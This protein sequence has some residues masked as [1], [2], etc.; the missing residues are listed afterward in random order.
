MKEEII[1]YAL[2]LGFAKV[3]FARAE[4]LHPEFEAYTEWL[5]NGFHAT[6][7]YM[8]E[9]GEK[10]LDVRN[11]LSEATTVIVL[12]FNY[13]SG[14]K[15]N[16]GLSGEKGKISRYA[17]G[18]DYHDIIKPK[19]K[20]I[21]EFIA[22]LGDDV[23]TWVYVDTGPVLEK[24]WASRAGIGWQGKHSIIITREFGSWIFLGIVLTSL[25]IEPDAPVKNFCGKCTKCI[26]A[27]PTSAILKPAVVDS[28]KCI[29]YWTI[30]AKPHML[31][32]VQIAGNMK[33]WLYGCDICQEVCPWNRDLDIIQL[34]ESFAPRN[35]ESELELDRIFNMTS[36]EFTARFRKSPAK[37]TKLDGLKR[38]AET[39]KGNIPNQDKNT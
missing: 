34:N 14:H 29:A 3:G 2:S 26:D 19:L 25:E 28:N 15:H 17:W 37:R 7:G 36:D 21:A 18:D 32:P 6:M 22:S 1:K 23:K 9:N 31:I 12:A 20:Q 39:L 5:E 10:R 8:A 16:G 35:G 38:N 11:I 27:C 13:Y 24:A 30:E 4:P 33:G